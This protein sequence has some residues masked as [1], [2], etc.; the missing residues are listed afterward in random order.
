MWI[1]VEKSTGRHELRIVGTWDRR[2][3]AILGSK[4]TMKGVWYVKAV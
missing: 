4:Q 2:G 1:G 3:F